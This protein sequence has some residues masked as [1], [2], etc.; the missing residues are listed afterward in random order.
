MA[1]IVFTISKIETDTIK[2]HYSPIKERAQYYL[3]LN[4]D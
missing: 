2:F 1:L 3:T 4:K